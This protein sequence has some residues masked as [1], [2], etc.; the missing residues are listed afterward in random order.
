MN[1][2]FINILHSF[3]SAGICGIEM[4]PRFCIER[5]SSERA[6]HV[7]FEECPSCPCHV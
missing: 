2:Y 1:D 6:V 5:N 7:M 4:G 3:L